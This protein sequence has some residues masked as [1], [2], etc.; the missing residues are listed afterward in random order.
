MSF[1]L[2]THRPTTS[3]RPG[4]ASGAFIVESLL[5]LVFL[6]GSL[7][8][9]TQMFAAAAEQAA[10][11]GTLSAAVAAVGNTA[12]QFAADPESVSTE[13]HEG[14]LRVVSDVTQEARE[15]GTLYRATIS[16]FDANNA[17]PVYTV[18]TSRYVS[19]VG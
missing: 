8:I 9:F 11:G 3:A 12:E 6:I 10:Q 14:D 15:G 17:T 16:A 1:E 18:T 19:E 13:T 2:P 4:W 7:A 5:L